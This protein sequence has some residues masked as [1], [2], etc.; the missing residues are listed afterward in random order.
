[1]AAETLVHGVDRGRGLPVDGQDQIARTQPCRGRQP[2]ICN[3]GD[4]DAR[5]ELMNPTSESS[6]PEKAVAKA[7]SVAVAASLLSA[8]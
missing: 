4:Q 7:R 2:A 8:T 3:A 5:R 1:M 6:A